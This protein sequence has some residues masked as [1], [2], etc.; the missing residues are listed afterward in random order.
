TQRGAGARVEHGTAEAA[1]S[2]SHISHAPYVDQIET[3]AEVQDPPAQLGRAAGDGQTVDVGRRAEDAEDARQAAG[4]YRE[5]SR[6]WA[7]D[8][9]CGGDVQLAGRQV[10]RPREARAESDDIDAGVGVGIENGLA[11]RACAVVVEG[12]DEEGTEHGA[13][14]E[15]L[16][17]RPAVTG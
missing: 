5:L 3:A 9:H 17:T 10:A 16:Q 7:L 4:A 6:A 1:V 2:S 12:R 15:C 8:V 14:F 13:W 11:E